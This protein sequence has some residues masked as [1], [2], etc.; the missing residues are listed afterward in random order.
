MNVFVCVSV[1]ILNSCFP[2]GAITTLTSEHCP[3]P[4]LCLR[5]EG[6]SVEK[7]AQWKKKYSECVKSIEGGG[8]GGRDG[9]F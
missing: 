6:N 8:V 7:R 3:A 5:R 9:K 1:S 2:P 4:H